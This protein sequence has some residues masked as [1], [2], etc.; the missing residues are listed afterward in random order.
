M[1]LFKKNKYFDLKSIYNGHHKVTY[2]G[3]SAIKCPFDYTLYQ[4][5]IW[6][7]QPDL[8]I[9]IGTN[10]GGSTLYMAD[11]L[12]ANGKGEIHTIDIPKNDENELLHLHPRIKIF[13]NGF[14]NYDTD[15]LSKFK[16]IL[17]IEDGSHQYEDCL[18]ALYKF[19][20]FVSKGSYFIMED[21]IVNKLNR[22]KEFN[23]GP[24]KAIKEFLKKNDSYSI[25][26]SWCNFFGE[27]TTFNIN[28]YLKR[29]K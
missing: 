4:M 25:E 14:A 23:G 10:K 26:K 8:I 5:I 24:Q 17:I 11:L 2:K 22:E 21:G 29:I 19:S 16:T 6:E 28:G 15:P 20:P 27:N 7:V 12:E 9:E 1:Y 13:K 18:N 3:V